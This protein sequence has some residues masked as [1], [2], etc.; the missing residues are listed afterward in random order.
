[1]FLQGIDGVLDR[2]GCQEEINQNHADSNPDNQ[3]SQ[4]SID[5]W[6]RKG[7]VEKAQIKTLNLESFVK[8]I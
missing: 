1:M 8:T 7:E 6:K 4:E 5:K 2:V 3:Q